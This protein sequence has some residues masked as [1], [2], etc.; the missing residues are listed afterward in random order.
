MKDVKQD[1]DGATPYECLQCGR[2]TTADDNPGACPD[3]G[4][5]IRNR[6]T[7]LE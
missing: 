4:G 6:Q 7:P 1:S 2:I 3:C 5:E